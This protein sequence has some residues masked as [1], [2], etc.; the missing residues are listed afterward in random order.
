MLI[1]SLIAALLLAGAISMVL[2]APH[3][4]AQTG[5]ALLASLVVWITHVALLVMYAFRPSGAVR[6]LLGISVIVAL[7][8]AFLLFVARQPDFQVQNVSPT[9]MPSRLPGAPVQ[10]S[11]I[12]QPPPSIPEHP[13]AIPQAPSSRPPRTPGG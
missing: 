13:P 4:H 11:S 7:L 10:P 8:C 1:L 6:M 2:G 5:F 3:A 12:P 9:L